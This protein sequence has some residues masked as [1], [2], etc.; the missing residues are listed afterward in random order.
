MRLAL[1]LSALFMVS[2]IVAG[3]VAWVVMGDELRG[4]LYDD[5]RVQAQALAAE[6]DTSGTEELVR[7]I[8]SVSAFGR[9]HGTLIFFLPGTGGAGVGNMT[10]AKLFEGPR[11][12]LAGRDLVLQ[13]DPGS[14]EGE[15]Y[16]GWG[17]RA[18]LGWIIV[19]RDSQWITDSQEVLIQAIAWGLGVALVATV[20]LAF[21]IG[22]RD[23]RR[24]ARINRVLA[25]VAAGE[26]TARYP[27]EDRTR[28]D[29]AE[30]A[31]GINRMLERL[32]A[33][34]ERLAQVSADI[35][36]DLRSPL[37]RLRLRLEPQALRNDLPEDTRAAIA[38]SLESL[39]GISAS[40]DAILQLS[41][42]ETGNMA[43]DAHPTD[44]RDVVRNVHEML[45]PVAEESGHTLDVALPEAPVRADANA[46][47]ISQ[48][49]VNLVDNA[50]RHTPPGTA[51]RIK[52]A[53]DEGAAQLSVCDNGPGIPAEERERVTRRFYRLDRSRSRPGTGLGLSLVAAIAQLHGGRLA[54][55]DNGPGL[56]ADIVLSQP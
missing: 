48:A 44:L 28:D 25:E 15:V 12:L 31:A 4:R 51:I 38:A 23:G 30:V 53:Q 50:L 26:F 27:E 10:P 5:S 19:A 43:L 18:P 49:L 37:T 46:D 52:V 34:V 7:Q 32:S 29:L 3:T 17:I 2:A 36:H 41:Q 40:F 13:P 47:L 20:F 55:S 14:Q 9:D 21:L 8:E 16:F 35:A 56:S 11:R 22:R 54:L 33:N 6:L 45:Q 1:S 24:V 42:I 39:D